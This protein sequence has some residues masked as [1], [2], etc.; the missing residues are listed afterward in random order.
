[1]STDCN[2]P[3]SSYPSDCQVTAGLRDIARNKQPEKIDG[4]IAERALKIQL[5]LLDVDGVLTDGTLIFS[6]EGG[7][8]KAFNTQDGFGISLLQKS[9]VD[10]GVITA[11]KSRAVEKR[12]TGL[13]MRYIYQGERNKL[14]AYNTIV[15]ESGL[16]PYQIAYMGD[17][18]LDLVLLKRVGFAIAPANAMMD[19]QEKVHYTTSRC[20]GQG[21]VREVCDL[22]L[23]AKGEYHKLLQSY[24]SR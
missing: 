23:K 15:G 13:N 9:G 11:R 3:S 19:V 22:I 5:L 7:E 10:V 14:E 12:C 24:M 1:M 4:R 2:N 16:K 8:S 17:D 21:A 6:P 18:W 20:G